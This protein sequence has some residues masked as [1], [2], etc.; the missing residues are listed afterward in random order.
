MSAIKNLRLAVRLGLGFGALALALLAVSVLAAGRIGALGGDIHQVST[1]DL[2]AVD[3]AGSVVARDETIGVDTVQLLYVHDGDAKAEDKLAAEIAQLAA[4]NDRDNASLARQLDGTRASDDLARF[5]AAEKKFVALY[6]EAIKRSRA[7]T[8]RNSED[9]SA[10]RGLYES[11]IIP[12][13]QAVAAA[14][15]TLETQVRKVADESSAQAEA[16]AG[17]AK[18]IIWI[19]AALAL[20]AAAAVATW[21][22]RSVTRPVAALGDRLRSLN[23]HCLAG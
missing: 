7:E 1:R 5:Q 22:T 3:S 23:A 12:A 20:L 6:T 16:N 11:R 13:Q 10:S 2:P 8:A 18:R 15:A 4:A 19:L 21:I 17:S 14:G 9:R